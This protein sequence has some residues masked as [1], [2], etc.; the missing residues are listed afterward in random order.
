MA[1]SKSVKNKKKR[2][3]KQKSNPVGRPAGSGWPPQALAASNIA[4]ENN[5]WW[6]QRSRH[7]REKLFSNPE[8]MWEAASEYFA[9]TNNRGGCKYEWKDKELR[10]IPLKT[11]YTMEALCLYMGV[12]PSYFR[13]F[14]FQLK[15]SDPQHAGFSAVISLIEGTVYNQKFEGA[16]MGHFNS[17]LISYDLGIRRDQTE[18]HTAGVVINVQDTGT[19]KL[20]EE[21]KAKLEKID[22]EK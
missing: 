4:S 5:E 12:H 20:L 6:K 1:K 14:K 21:I 17:Q 2:T 8:L 11:P 10:A 3:L 9:N 18:A 7:G 19:S 13:N 16:A 15:K 22:E